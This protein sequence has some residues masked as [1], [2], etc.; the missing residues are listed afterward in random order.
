MRQLDRL[1]SHI[2]ERVCEAVEHGVKERFYF[3]RVPFPRVD[4]ISPGMVKGPRHRYMPI[5]S[6]VRTD[7]LAIV[8]QDLRPPPIKPTA[9]KGAAQSRIDFEA[10]LRHR[11]GDPGPSVAM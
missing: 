6:P 10:A 1:F 4:D 9:P 5:T 8:R 11:P 7:L 2:D 3:L